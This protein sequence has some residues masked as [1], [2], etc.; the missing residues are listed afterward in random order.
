MD[1]AT[2][3]GIVTAFA[4]VLMAIMMG[5]S[6]LLFLNIPGLMIVV[7]GTLGS[8][9]INYPL[10]DVMKVVKVVK[11]A[12]FH[13]TLRHRLCHRIC[14]GR[15]YCAFGAGL[16]QSSDK[17]PFSPTPGRLVTTVLPWVIE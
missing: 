11:N 16:L 4:L 14:K 10:P 15:Q 7:G 5:G 8:T 1:I 17:A 9:L 12:F 6:V 13:Q 2:L 3:V